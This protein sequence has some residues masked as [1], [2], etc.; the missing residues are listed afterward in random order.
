[1]SCVRRDARFTPRSYLY[2]SLSCI[3]STL[4]RLF[5]SVTMAVIRPNAISEEEL[6]KISSELS[7]TEIAV[8]GWMKDYEKLA[9][10]SAQDGE[11]AAER[12]YKAQ[13]GTAAMGL[14][15]VM[16]RL[17]GAITA[18]RAAPEGRCI[19]YMDQLKKHLERSQPLSPWAIFYMG[20]SMLMPEAIMDTTGA[21]LSPSETP[22]R[23]IEAW[24]YLAWTGGIRAAKF[25]SWSDAM[26]VK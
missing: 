6:D 13:Q 10:T 25:R 9:A 12:D 20:Q 4:P 21:W 2:L 15:A 22:T 23:I 18:D 1:M 11:S 7:D 19:A 26:N 3:G 5:I 8:R 16:C 14:M 24:K 17:Q